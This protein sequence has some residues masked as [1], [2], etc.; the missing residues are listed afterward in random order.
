VTPEAANRLF[1]HEFLG[2]FTLGHYAL[3]YIR[4]HN[5]LRA[6]TSMWFLATDSSVGGVGLAGRSEPN[7][8]SL[9]EEIQVNEPIMVPEDLTGLSDEQL[10][11]L[12][13]QIRDRVEGLADEAR[14]SDETLSEVESLIAS[15]DRVSQTLVTR[16]AA[17]GERAAAVDAI[18]GRFAPVEDATAETEDEAP[19]EAAT[20]A[21][22]EDPAVEE[23][24]AETVAAA[25][26]TPVELAVE[27]APEVAPVIVAE[28]APVTPTAETVEFTAVAPAVEVVEVVEITVEAATE[29]VSEMTS[30][31]TEAT[32]EAGT[33]PQEGTQV[34]TIANATAAGL[35]DHR[36]DGVAP[37]P[38]TPAG[39]T[40]VARG[41]GEVAPEGQTIDLEMLAKAIVDKT[42]HRSNVPS[43]T[44]DMVTMASAMADFPTETLG[45]SYEQNF[46]ILSSVA[47]G[48]T[49]ARSEETAMVASGGNCAPLEQDYGFF[50]LA[51]EMNPVERALPVAPAPR[52]GIRYIQ[53]PDFRDA[54]PGVR[55]TTEAEDA[56]GYVSNG[57]STADKPCTT[58]EC[59]SIQECRVDAV[60]RCV[61]FGNLNYRV[62]PEQVQSFLK[63]LSVIFTET[64]E[65][66]YL[67][68]IDAASTAVTAANTYGATRAIIHDLLVASA[69]YRRRHH[70]SPTAT[71][72]LLLPSWLRELIDV[73]MVNDHAL[74]MSF[75]G[76]DSDMALSRFFAGANLDVSYYYDSATGA[77]QAFNHAQGAGAL[78]DFPSTVVSYIF[79]PGTYVRRDAG[80]L[81]VGL[82]SDSVLNGT[83]DLQLFAEQWIQVCMVG[84]ESLRIEHTLCPDGTG[85]EPV[86]PMVCPGGIS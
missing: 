19:V 29:A 31:A 16:E 58:V 74:G 82:V 65:I 5:E 44:F 12:G 64:K 54:A 70:M 75:V 30:L 50:R 46:S 67:D 80:T 20:E 2:S 22:E 52:G 62:F 53:P 81:D 45:G 48:F 42:V 69:N 86:T 28:P 41:I 9:M 59:P 11:E 4:D 21:A 1:I 34:E 43:G 37:R 33:E 25:I 36:P 26:E 83:N 7:I 56:A 24:P 55:V 39:A 15:Y 3:A 84:L 14:T 8:D 49:T 10:S 27:A 47:Q 6:Y 68:A 51:E 78:N 72:T 32:V 76:V 35:L 66:F 23:D 38:V 60:S 79:A 85:P 71:L 73:D 40:F 57:G 18:M 13:L 63:D 17:A 61:T 77:G